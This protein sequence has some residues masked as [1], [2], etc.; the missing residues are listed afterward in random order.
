MTEKENSYWKIIQKVMQRIKKIQMNLKET[1]LVSVVLVTYNSAQY[2]IE[3][4]ESIKAQTWQQIEL[5]VSDD[6]STDKTVELC[7]N[8]IDCNKGRF[9][10]TKMITVLQNSGIPANCNRGLKAAQGEWVK[11]IS[12]DDILIKDCISDNMEYV[13]RFPDASFVVSDIREID[14]NGVLIHERVVNEGL[15][16]FVNIPS[17]GKQLKAYSRWP[18]FLN[19]PTFFYRREVM[20]LVGYCD[21]E[22]RIYE[23]MVTIFKVTEKGIKV[24]YLNKATVDYRIHRDSI[25]RC[26]KAEMLRENEA[27]EIFR[28]Y[29][30]R[31][32]S[33]FNPL[34]MSVCYE[35]WLQFKYKGIKGWKGN[36]I[37]RKFSLFYWYVRFYGV[38]SY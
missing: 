9:S 4:L 10:K 27:L 36:S 11:I 30:R 8:W 1:P 18:A 19:S 31:N 17:A 21:E 37:L 2:V 12:G 34:D 22:F 3:T 33:I 6:C 16:F 13:R 15:S 28:K 20:E 29:R 32:L 35:S 38:K 26:M 5:I 14:E 23:D 24:H 7:S 25:S